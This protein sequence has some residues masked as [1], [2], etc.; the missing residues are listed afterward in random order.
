MHRFTR[1]ILAVLALLVGSSTP[2]WGQTSQTVSVPVTLTLVPFLSCVAD[3]GI[4][5]GSVHR[6]QGTVST[7]ST[8][9]AQWQCDTDPGSSLNFTFTLP[10]AMTNPSATSATVPLSFGATS[11]FVNCNG[12]V[13][14]PASGLAN[15]VCPSGHAVVQLGVP[16]GSASDLVTANVSGASPLGGGAYTA[17]ITMNVT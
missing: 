5:Y 14:N 4:A 16:R 17:T 13:F 7:S 1:F 8:S 10:I 3:G 15:D 11:A 9:F 2:S 12:S 6:S